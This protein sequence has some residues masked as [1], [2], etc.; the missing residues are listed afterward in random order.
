M[1]AGKK[2]GHTMF[3]IN[4]IKM[5]LEKRNDRS[6][7]NQGVTEYAL[8]LLD[9]LEENREY[10]SKDMY[11]HPI[12]VESELLNG[13]KDWAQYSWGGCSF[14]YNWD[15][16]TRLCCPSELERNR[17]GERRPNRNEE[18]LDV[19]ARALYQAAQRIK[20]I[21]RRGMQ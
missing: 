1:A 8:D 3:T 14:I 17:N 4:D 7:W 21:A 15:I 2:K 18:W 13:A 5:E 10:E 16:A 20:R 19:Q 11:V 12:E 9:A 6:A